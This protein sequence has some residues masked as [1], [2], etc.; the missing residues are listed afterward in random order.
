MHL[1]YSTFIYSIKLAEII[2]SFVQAKTYLEE[3]QLD[4]ANSKSGVATFCTIVLT[5]T[6]LMLIF[7]VIPIAIVLAL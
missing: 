2:F 7:C 6:V 4:K 1:N 5:F 3:N